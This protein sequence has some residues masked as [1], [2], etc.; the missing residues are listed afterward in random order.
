LK[1]GDLKKALALLRSGDYIAVQ[2]AEQL[3]VSRHTLWR[4]LSR[5]VAKRSG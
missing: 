5:A 3:E 1:E 2:V 4:A